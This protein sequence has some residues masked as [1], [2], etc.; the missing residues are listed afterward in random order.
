MGLE[1]KK[2]GSQR[3]GRLLG[4]ALLVVCLAVALASCG[5][6]GSSS[7]S[8]SS[9]TGEEP[10]SGEEAAGGA[11]A[12]VKAAEKIVEE[13]K[14]EPTEV[15]VTEPLKEKPAPGKTIVWLNC[16]FEQ[17]QQTGEAMEEA[18]K[19]LGYTLK[20][21]AYKSA[22]PATLIAA[23]KQAL[24]YNPVGVALSGVNS[25]AWPSVIPEYE[26]AGVPIVEGLAGPQETNGALVANLWNEEDLEKD[27]VILAN[28]MTVESNGEGSAVVLGVPEFPILSGFATA[29][30]KALGEAC[31]GCSAS[32]TNATIA[33][34]GSPT[35]S[36]SLLVSAAQ[37][38]SDAEFVIT[39][40]GALSPGLPAALSGA[41]LEGK[42]VAGALGT[43]NSQ[44]EI[45]A[46]KAAAFTGQ[47]VGYYGWALVDSILRADQGMEIPAGDG[48]MPHQ[49]LDKENV[50]TPAPS[51][52]GPKEYSAQFEEL[53]KL[54]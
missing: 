1:E 46:G 10:T 9:N 47:N 43:E 5:G 21:V 32:S 7:S 4:I 27:A 48:G 38:N 53:W 37:K 6:G 19:P 8:S 51:N 3:R 12:E 34:I 50:G 39:C 31:S 29:F 33:Q 42:K 25:A 2:R 49:L 14:A 22:E 45:I 54:G 18:V 35:E 28:W 23:F 36:N 16:D 17:C 30:S 40:D 44:A 24:Q 15:G 26:K 11:S 20:K 13:A 41:G 52:I